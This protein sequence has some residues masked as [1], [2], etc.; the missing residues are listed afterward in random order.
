MARMHS[1]A[2]GVSGSTKPIKKVVPGW[3]K[4]SAKEAELLV[5]KYAKEEKKPSQIGIFLRDQYGIPDIKVVTGKTIT[6]IL[7]EKKVKQDLPEDFL[8]LIK[9]SVMLRKHLEINKKDMSAKRGL[10]LTDS[11]IRRLAKYYKTKGILEAKWRYNA[12][13]FKMYAQD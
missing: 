10:Q 11:K 3:L 13:Q 4:Y 12:D 7:K 8:A 1:R 6:Q 2:K 5:V 9:K